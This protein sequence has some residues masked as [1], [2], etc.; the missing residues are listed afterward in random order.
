MPRHLPDRLFVPK[1]VFIAV[2]VQLAH[3]SDCV[4]ITARS[5]Q[6][7][8]L[9]HALKALHDA[10]LHVGNLQEALRAIMEEETDPTPPTSSSSGSVNGTGGLQAHAG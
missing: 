4:L 1:D 9:D 10:N 2:C 7:D 5:L 3:L 8:N 6:T